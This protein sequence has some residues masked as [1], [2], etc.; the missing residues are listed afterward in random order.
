M[1]KLKDEYSLL[2][3]GTVDCATVESTKAAVTRIDQIYRYFSFLGDYAGQQRCLQAA[4]T[5]M[6]NA[7]QKCK[8]T[9]AKM[10]GKWVIGKIKESLC[11]GF[12]TAPPI[13]LPPPALT[14]AEP[15]IAE[16]E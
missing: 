6:S 10:Y 5:G 1:P 3:E 14:P 4:T 15:E 7:L 16:G 11:V 12:L 8:K 9:Q 13:K 2:F